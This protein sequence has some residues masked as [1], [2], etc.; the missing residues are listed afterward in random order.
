MPAVRTRAVMSN[1]R[2]AVKRFRLSTLLLLIAIAALCIALVVQQQQ[3][4][5]WE[6]R[7]AQLQNELNVLRE[8]EARSQKIM[9]S[10][11]KKLRSAEDQKRSAGGKANAGEVRGE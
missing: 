9:Q 7:I 6:A 8:I 1:P 11:A 5:R 10:Q 2:G 4:A 3:V